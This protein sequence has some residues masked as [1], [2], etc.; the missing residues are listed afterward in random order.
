MAERF[1]KPY[2]DALFDVAETLYAVEA[3]VPGLEAFA[4]TIAR[5]DDLRAVIRNPGLDRASKAAVV[6]AIAQK[7]ELG[8]LGTRFLTT[9]L[10][11]RRLHRLPDVIL[12]IRERVDHD[13]KVQEAQ[14]RTAVALEEP[15]RREL[16]LALEKRTGGK[17]R[18]LHE[19]DPTLIGGFVLRVG[20]E[21]YDASLK[22]RLEKAR[23]AL[24][25]PTAV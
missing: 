10:G 3:L 7:E 2:V 17:I 4:K 25:T 13:R 18:L 24:H 9:L 23:R 21:V 16:R 6:Q 22:K 5:S 11:N 14:L 12:A 20:S 8:E 1:A 19:V 15:V